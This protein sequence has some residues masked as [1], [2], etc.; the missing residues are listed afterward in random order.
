MTRPIGGTRGGP[1]RLTQQES[2]PPAKK[3]PEAEAPAAKKKNAAASQ[4]E[5]GFE[6]PSARPKP[7]PQSTKG[8]VKTQPAAK[9]PPPPA[10][11]KLSEAVKKTLDQQLALH[12]KNSAAHKTL[13]DLAASPGFAGLKAADQQKLLRYVG[14]T[15]GD[16]SGPARAGLSQLMGADAF[17]KADAAKQKEQL[18]KFLTEQP[19]T[20]EVVLTPKDAFKDKRKAYKL[21]GPTDVKNHDF[22]GGKA[23]A[24]KYE[25]EIDGKKIPVFLPKS[26]KKD[27]VHSIQEMAKGLAALPASSRALVKQV[28]VEAKQNPDDAYWA[29]QYNDPN[30][31]S[32]MTA[33]ADGIINVY[34][35]KPKQSQ[36]YL[37][38]TLI[39]E[40]G[41]TLSMKKW[42]SDDNDK[43]WN[44]WKAAIKS[45]GIVPS[46][47]GK[48]SVGEDFSET[49]V[50]YHQ[51]KGTPQEAE[52]RALMPERFKIIDEMLAGKR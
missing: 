31:S 30:F 17:K 35:S 51:S 2:P 45:D 37:D 44:D 20:P 43:R 6:A 22:R 16:L 15:N 14:G 7:A 41:H 29:Q 39:H 38:G 50:L 24:V 9:P 1:S 3:P 23:D 40:T 8:S 28:V 27:E 25:V 36:D 47:Y 12:P 48:A 5:S 26:P 4:Y 42:G 11:P 13:S 52:L 10:T 46:K 18:Q 34:P 19:A 32:Y 21:H 33:G 49:L